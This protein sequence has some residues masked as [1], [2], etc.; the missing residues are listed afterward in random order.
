MDIK[1][2]KRDLNKKPYCIELFNKEVNENAS[3][4]AIFPEHVDE[5]CPIE[6]QMIKNGVY[7]IVS[8]G[9][10]VIADDYRVEW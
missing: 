6:A 8:G 7:L 5:F 1:K 2:F 10:R 9:M 3:V 4:G